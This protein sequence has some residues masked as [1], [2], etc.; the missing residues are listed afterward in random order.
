MF[1]TLCH[2]LLMHIFNARL[3]GHNTMLAFFFFQKTVAPVEINIQDSAIY[4]FFLI[5]K[6]HPQQS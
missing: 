1:L 3:I 6:L 2:L 5:N 4:Y